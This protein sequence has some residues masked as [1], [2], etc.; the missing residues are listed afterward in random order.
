MARKSSNRDH[1]SNKD[2]FENLVASRNAELSEMDD[3]ARSQIDGEKPKDDDDDDFEESLPETEVL[4]ESPSKDVVADDEKGGAAE[5]S[6]DDF[7]SSDSFS[8]KLKTKISGVERDVTLDELVRNFQK[9][10]SGDARL[11]EATR[12]ERELMERERQLL[13]MERQMVQQ[14]KQPVKDQ[15]V[16]EDNKPSRSKDAFKAAAIAILEGD[17]EKSAALFESA[18]GEK[19]QAELERRIAIMLPELEERAKRKAL[20]AAP[21]IQMQMQW[22]AAV[23]SAVDSNSDLF[24]DPILASAWREKVN[25]AA[26]RGMNPYDAVKEAVSEV[27]AWTARFKGPESEK[28]LDVNRDEMGRREEKKREASKMDVQGKASTRS[29]RQKSDEDE[30]ESALDII[31]AMRKAR[32]FDF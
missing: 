19:I 20:E 10:E 27:N 24:N 26:S 9:G 16:I 14:L 31:N 15:K 2:V 8:K 28:K 30:E 29:V 18:A 4:D 22:D 7:L 21:E 32:G 13:D 1:D 23:K 25:A 5:I 12:K 3:W 6:A 17:D 11:Q